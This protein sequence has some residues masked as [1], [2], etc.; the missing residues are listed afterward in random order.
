M[1]FSTQGAL[2]G[3]LGIGAVT[4]TVALESLEK[5]PELSHDR[6]SRAC[7]FPISPP[8]PSLFPCSF[9]KISQVLA[10]SELLDL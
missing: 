2:S 10:Q 7:F 9:A 4:C 5:V 8:S 3:T 6:D 1:L